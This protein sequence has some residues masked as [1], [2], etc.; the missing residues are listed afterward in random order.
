M[1][2]L[3]RTEQH[4]PIFLSRPHGYSIPGYS[5][6]IDEDYFALNYTL[7]NARGHGHVYL[8]IGGTSLR[9]YDLLASVEA[10][11]PDELESSSIIQGG[12][13][14]N[15]TVSV[16]YGDGIYLPSWPAGDVTLLEQIITPRTEVVDLLVSAAKAVTEDGTTNAV[17]Q[18]RSSLSLPDLAASEYYAA[19][20]YDTSGNGSLLLGLHFKKGTNMVFAHANTTSES[21]GLSK[22]FG[23]RRALLHVMAP[24][25]LFIWAWLAPALEA[26]AV[27]FYWTFVF[28]LQCT[29]LS[30]CLW[31]I[32]WFC[33]GKPSLERILGVFTRIRPNARLDRAIMLA[34]QLRELKLQDPKLRKKDFTV[35]DAWTIWR[36]SKQTVTGVRDFSIFH[37]P[38]RWK[39]LERLDNLALPRFFDEPFHAS[40]SGLWHLVKH[41]FSS[42][43]DTG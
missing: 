3:F 23:F 33:L 36:S 35:T 19:G 10:S 1:L 8:T 32:V 30:T 14:I 15:S 13:R 5:R 21:W 37:K 24:S 38:A 18:I 25:A 6:P 28:T 11:S 43:R 34:E 7:S 17:V 41:A 26:F 9:V 12:Q 40:A 27:V 16:A 31:A 2:T 29:I 20:G 4:W 42:N 39:R 22:T